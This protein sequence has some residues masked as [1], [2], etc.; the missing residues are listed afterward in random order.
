[1]QSKCNIKIIIMKLFD[2]IRIS[3]NENKF[4]IWLN[5]EYVCLKNSFNHMKWKSF[6]IYN[7]WNFWVVPN[8]NPP[9]AATQD[10]VYMIAGGDIGFSDALVEEEKFLFP[11]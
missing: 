3:N 4:L 8:S 5:K 6:I 7:H 11:N 1:M 10:A 2:I 9:I